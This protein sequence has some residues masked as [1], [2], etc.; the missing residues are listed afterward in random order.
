MIS[1]S[2]LSPLMQRAIKRDITF[3]VSKSGLTGYY[4]LYFAKYTIGRGNQSV[5]LM[6][7]QET[8]IIYQYADENHPVIAFETVE[9]VLSY[10]QKEF[11]GEEEWKDGSD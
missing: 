9:D 10:V 8:G 5:R 6:Y 4:N 2:D 3:M 11:K 7:H 1:L